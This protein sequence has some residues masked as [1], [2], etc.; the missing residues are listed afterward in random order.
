MTK[1]EDLVKEEL[2]KQDKNVVLPFKN[3]KDIRITKATE[4]VNVVAKIGEW[5]ED[6]KLKGITGNVKISLGEDKKKWQHGLMRISIKDKGK[7]ISKLVHIDV[8]MTLIYKSYDPNNLE[9][10]KKLDSRKDKSII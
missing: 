3:K 5:T 9:R 8:I 6:A 7:W 1:G 4:Y 10:V 2:I